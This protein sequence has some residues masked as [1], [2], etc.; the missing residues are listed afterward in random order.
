MKY[1]PPEGPVEIVVVRHGDEVLLSVR[2]RGPGI[3]PAWRDKVFDAFRRGE[4]PSSRAGSGA[5]VGLAVCRAIARAHGGELT[6][7]ARN[8]GGAS[9]DCRLPLRS[10]PVA[11][12]EEAAS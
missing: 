12:T 10:A 5:G 2:D 7:G 8:R 11:P 4:T 6:V 3:A 1:G 9:F